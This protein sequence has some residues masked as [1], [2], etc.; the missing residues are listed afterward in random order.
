MLPASPSSPLRDTQLEM[1]LHRAT[2]SE[3]TRISDLMDLLPQ[4]AESALD[5]GSRDGFISRLL[6]DR[7]AKVTALDLDMPVIDDARIQCVKGDITALSFADGAF[8]LIFCAEVLE[9]VPP[10]VLEKAGNELGRAAK[11]HVLIGVP[12]KQDIRVGRSTCQR[13]GKINP[14]YG[15]VNSFDEN[16][17]KALFPDFAIVKT[18]YVGES[19]ARTNFI[20]CAL[21]DL[22]GNPYG[23]YTQDEPCIY[24]G[25]TFTPPRERKLWQ[26]VCTKMAHWGNKIQLPPNSKHAYWIHVLL[27]RQQVDHEQH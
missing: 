15:H 13:C 12:Y 5:I 10:Q 25:A 24:C 23:T 7:Y 22:A 8:D 9:Q 27:E 21:M 6:A 16:S 14:P 26:K 11:R 20:S 1:T 18:S 17:L 2:L 4:C 19:D 3:E